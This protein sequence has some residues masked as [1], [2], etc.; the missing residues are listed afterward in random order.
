MVILIQADYETAE[1][2]G[3]SGTFQVISITV[4][5]VDYTGKIDQGKH[6]HSGE[7]LERNIGSHA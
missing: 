6:Y 4:D 5:D 3:A 1:R 7:E 2:I